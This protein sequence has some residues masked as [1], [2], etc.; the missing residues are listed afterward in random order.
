MK[1]SIY[2]GYNS[3]QDLERL[4][5]KQHPGPTNTLNKMLLKGV[6]FSELAKF[7]K[8]DL[9]AQF[10]LKRSN[11]SGLKGHIKYCEKNGWRFSLDIENFIEFEDPKKIFQLLSIKKI[12]NHKPANKNEET[13][14]KAVTSTDKRLE[15]IIKLVSKRV[16]SGVESIDSVYRFKRTGIEAWFKVEVVAALGEEVV[17][18]NNR[19]PDLTLADGTLIEL[20]AATDFNPSYLRNGAIKD[21]VPCLFLGDGEHSKFINRLSVMPEIRVIGLEYIYGDHTWVVGCIEPNFMK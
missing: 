14:K 11:W 7:L 20:K 19:G 12:L 8:E 9:T 18:L 1:N 6:T 3:L 21:S 2:S 4:L 17:K 15:E 13:R 10:S 5:D 16:H